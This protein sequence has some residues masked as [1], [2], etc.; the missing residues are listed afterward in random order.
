[1][2]NTID[3]QTNKWTNSSSSIDTADL[4]Y[5]LTTFDPNSENRTF[6]HDL[7][8]II[9]SYYESWK[10]IIEVGGQ[11][12]GNLFILNSGFQKTLLDLDPVAIAK[13]KQIFEKYSVNADCIEGDMFKMPLAAESYDIVFNSWVLEHFTQEERILAIREYAR[14][15]KP[16]G[17]MVLAVPNHNSWLYRFY[18]VFLDKIGLWKIPAEFKIKNFN[19]EITTNWLSL[20][21]TQIVSPQVI[22]D[23][24]NALFGL[25]TFVSALCKI[26]W[27]KISQVNVAIWNKRI[28][29]WNVIKLFHK[30][31]PITWYLLVFVIRK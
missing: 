23:N 6:Y 12:W 3:S 30:I 14:I 22:F 18:Y 17:V 24:Y 20:L 29:L 10:K 1:M 19:K 9:D 16:N 11:F 21:D 26:F 27:K 5:F 25:G 31:Y 28:G 13:A 8:Q 2:A 4:E 15:L 7:Y